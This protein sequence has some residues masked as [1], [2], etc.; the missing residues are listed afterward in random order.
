MKLSDEIKNAPAI[1][2]FHAVEESRKW[3]TAV[4]NKTKGMSTEELIAF[5]KRCSPNIPRASSR[6]E[7]TH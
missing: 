2:G 4:T 1:E 3:K 7:T 6:T 5:F